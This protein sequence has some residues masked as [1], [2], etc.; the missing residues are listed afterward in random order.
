MDDLYHPGPPMGPPMM[1]G[2]HVSPSPF[3]V[4]VWLCCPLPLQHR[5]P[6]DDKLVLNKHS[7]IYPNEAEV[8]VVEEGGREALTLL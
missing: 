8:R 2:F 5:N 7:L 4:G 1:G 3:P 6:R